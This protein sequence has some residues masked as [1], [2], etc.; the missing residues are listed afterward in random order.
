MGT[1]AKE[2]V[3]L[4][5]LAN[6]TTGVDDTAS[7][8][9]ILQPKNDSYPTNGIACSQC[10]TNT[11]RWRPDNDLDTEL[12]YWIYVDAVIKGTLS[13][14]DGISMVIGGD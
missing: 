10:T 3:P 5:H 2:D 6:W 13:M 7:Y 14:R 4:I 1:W 11:Y 8:T 12:D 9:V